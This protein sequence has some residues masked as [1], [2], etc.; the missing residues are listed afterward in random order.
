VLWSRTPG[1]VDDRGEVLRTKAFNHLALADSRL[2]PY[3]AASLQGLKALGLLDTLQPRFVT[4]ANNTQAYQ[5]VA[6]GN[7][8]L[9]FVALSQVYKGGRIAE[10]S[11]WIVPQALY[12][13]IRQDAV[14]LARG[15][16]K[17]AVEA[18][19]QYLRGDKAREIIQSYGYTL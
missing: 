10:G 12:Q 13:P 14:M 17:P 15:K 6:S 2:A 19:L 5:F 4:A 7:A 3:G 16:G 8:E 11:G 18:F 1:F 9:G